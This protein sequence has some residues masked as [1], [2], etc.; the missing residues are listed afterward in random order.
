MVLYVVRFGVRFCTV[1]PSVCID[2]ITG[3]IQELVPMTK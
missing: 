3:V 1:S 2:D